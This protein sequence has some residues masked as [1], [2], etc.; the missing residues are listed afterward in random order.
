M[1]MEREELHSKLEMKLT[2]C[3]N[4]YVDRLLAMKPIEIIGKSAEIATARFCYD[5]LTE[6]TASYP[7]DLLEYLLGSDDPLETLREQW[8]NSQCADHSGELEH[9]MQ[10]LWDHDLQSGESHGM[11]SMS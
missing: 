8:M 9:T 6:N 7:E 4:A 11:D 2:S 3:W 5:E 10:P 1:V